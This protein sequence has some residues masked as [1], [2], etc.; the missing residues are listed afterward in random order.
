MKGVLSRTWASFRCI[1]M[2]FYGLQVFV[3]SLNVYESVQ[4]IWS[5][6]IRLISLTTW[7]TLCKIQIK[8]DCTVFDCYWW[9]EGLTLI[10]TVSGEELFKF[11]SQ[12]HVSDRFL[13]D[14][15]NK[16]VFLIANYET[17]YR[18]VVFILVELSLCQRFMFAHPLCNEV[19]NNY[20]MNW[21]FESYLGVSTPREH[22]SCY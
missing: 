22:P 2:I 1:T 20:L 8:I 11:N 10:F 15:R 6:L 3:L 21:R 7:I 17:C 19:C 18:C 12:A 9:N 13:W 14:K 5:K 4:T 16:H